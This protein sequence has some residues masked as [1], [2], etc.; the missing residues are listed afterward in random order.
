MYMGMGPSWAIC[1]RTARFCVIA[2][3][4][5]S[6]DNLCGY[7]EHCVEITQNAK[8]KGK[9]KFEKYGKIYQFKIESFIQT[10]AA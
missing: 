8:M 1:I 10:T 2:L 6:A 7:I 9:F 4:T 3:C 5:D